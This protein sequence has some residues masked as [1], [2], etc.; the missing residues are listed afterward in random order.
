MGRRCG[1]T[2]P[3]PCSGLCDAD[4]LRASQLL[5]S[6]PVRSLSPRE[7][8]EAPRAEMQTPPVTAPPGVLVSRHPRRSPVRSRSDQA[9]AKRPGT[10]AVV[11]TRPSKPGAAAA[12]CSLVPLLPDPLSVA[13]WYPSGGWTIEAG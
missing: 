7:P 11:Q 4:V 13:D 1:R 6:V 2:E 8:V 10:A 9:S 5:H 12:A 3:D